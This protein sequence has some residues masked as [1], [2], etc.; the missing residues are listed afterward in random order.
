[1][2]RRNITTTTENSSYS[3]SQVINFY[4]RL[5]ASNLTSQLFFAPPIYNLSFPVSDK[6][7]PRILFCL[8]LPL[9]LSTPLNLYPLTFHHHLLRLRQILSTPRTVPHSPPGS[10]ELN[11]MRIWSYDMSVPLHL[12]QCLLI[13]ASLQFHCYTY[14]QRICIPEQCAFDRVTPHARQHP[15]NRRDKP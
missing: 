12:L 4:Y 8:H 3:G 6:P 14:S 7:Q 9:V 2:K 5:I 13:A 1:M 10:Q 15:R 11:K